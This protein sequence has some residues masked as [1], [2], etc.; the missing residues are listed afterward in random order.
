MIDLKFVTLETFAIQTVILLVI[1][2]V[3]NKFVFTPYLA[4]LDQIEEK[5]KKV[6]EDYKNIEHIT[7]EAEKNAENIISEARLKWESLIGEAETIAK[8]KR[9]TILAKAESEAKDF[10]DSGK[11][12]IEK[13]RTSMVNSLKGMVVDLMMK[14]HTKI[15]KDEKLSRDF[16]EKSLQDITH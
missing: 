14:L 7:R 8:K 4:Y 5:Q 12:E 16:V 1:L 9:E 11:N 2:W 10:L 6:E 3:L 13:E 15:L